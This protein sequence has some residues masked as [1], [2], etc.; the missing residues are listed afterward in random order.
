M[1]FLIT[2]IATTFIA[3][4]G[5]LY[6]N[7][8]VTGGLSDVGNVRVLQVTPEN[9]LLANRSAYQPGSLPA[10]FDQSAGTGR[11]LRG[12][13][14]APTPAGRSQ[15]RP[16]A[17]AVRLPPKIPNTQYTIGVGDVILLATPQNSAEALEGL[18]AAQNSRQGYTIQDDGTISIPNVGRVQIAGLSIA[19]AEQV[20]FD[21]LIQA[22]IEPTFSLEI[23]DFNSKS[24]SFGGAIA[25]PGVVPITLQPLYLDAALASAGGVTAADPDFAVARLYRNGTLYQVPV[26]KLYDGTYER[27]RLQDGDSVFV[28]AEYELDQASDFFRQQLEVADFKRSSRAAAIQELEIEVSLRRAEL[29]E[30]RNNFQTKIDLDAI[31]RDYVYLTGEV[32]TQGRYTL[33]FGRNASLMDALYEGGEGL[34]LVSS[35][36]REIYVLRGSSDPMEFDSVTAWNLNIKNAAGLTLASRF[37]MRPNDIIFASPMPVTKWKR[38]IDQITPTIINVAATSA[39]AG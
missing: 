27:I 36:A 23:S 26:S 19:A 32:N 22:Q 35:D 28:D 39:G 2:F 30:Q 38:I 33:P 34:S 6:H 13:A 4:C 15:T 18:L 9:V 16:Q 1:R 10:V 5:S 29:A 7:P 14:I 20:L 17:L 12:S 3:S 21:R 25:T 31:D 11:G 24:V 37:E 8:N